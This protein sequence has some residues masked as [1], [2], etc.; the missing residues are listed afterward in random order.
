MKDVEPGELFSAIVMGLS[1][2]AIMLLASVV[3]G[4]GPTIEDVVCASSEYIYEGEDSTDRRSTVRYAGCTATAIGPHTVLSAAHCDGGKTVQILPSTTDS[5]LE[6]YNVVETIKHPDY[7]FPF[8]DVLIVYVDGVLPEPYAEL[9]SV[10]ELDGCAKF[11]AQGFGAGSVGLDE[12]QVEVLRIENDYIRIDGVAC[13]G[14]SGG[15]LWA[16]TDQGPL[17][18]GIATFGTTKTCGEGEPG[19]TKV[20]EYFDWIVERIL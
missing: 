12:K 14:D 3:S 17:Q 6:Y 20:S 8:G 5:P 2:G 19:Y 9:D 10:P 4:C 16:V 15:P 11:I 7:S 18:V 13:I 1:I